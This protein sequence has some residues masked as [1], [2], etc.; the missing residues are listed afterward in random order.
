MSAVITLGGR[1]HLEKLLALVTSFH[2]EEGISSTD[3]SRRAGIT[4]L[5]EGIP[6]G[7]AYLIGPPRAPIG[8]IVITFGWSVEFGGLDGIIDELYIRPGVRGRGIAS[9]ALIALP[10]ALAGAGLRAMHLEVD[11]TNAQALKLYRRAGFALR[12]NYAFMSKRL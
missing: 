7:C 11:K 4:P 6:H 9:E 5:L 12:E 2:A 1:D 3:E 8:Y 10:R